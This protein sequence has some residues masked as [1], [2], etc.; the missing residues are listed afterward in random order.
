MI[1][2]PTRRL[3]L[4]TA[5]A[6]PGLARA[7]FPER[8]I[9]LV[10]PYGG[11][12]QTDIVSRVTAD[13]LSRALGQPVLADNR[14]G[15]AGNLAAETVARSPAD[16]HT[17]LVATAATN[18]G[19]NALLYRQ[20]GYDWRTDFAPVGQFCATYNVLLVHRSVPGADFAAVLEWIRQNPGRFT[21]ASAGVGASTHLIME[22][23]GARLGLE[24]VHVPYRQSTQAMTDMLSGRVLSR[25]IG[26]PEGATVRDQPEIRPVALSCAGR[27]ADWPGVPAMGETILGFT[28]GSYFG[29]VAPARTP[30]EVVARLNAALGEALADPAVQAGYARVGADAVAPHPPAAFAALAKAEHERWAPLIRRLN[31]VAE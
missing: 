4:G 12:G 30:P 31:L 3:L 11:G 21:F 20:L 26:L 15:G 24:M 6:A 27:R 23:I 16:G 29:L 10:I 8:P 19:L 18:S 1:P 13:A 9:R 22:D 17:L 5:L 2:S 25:C 7:A 14:P 28:G